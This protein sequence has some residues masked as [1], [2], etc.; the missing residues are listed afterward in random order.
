MP[1][2]EEVAELA[3]PTLVWAYIP[4]RKFIGWR[5]RSFRVMRQMA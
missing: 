2:I 1:G 3:A 4:V 5:T